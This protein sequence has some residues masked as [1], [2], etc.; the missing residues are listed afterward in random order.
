MKPQQFKAM[1]YLDVALG[2]AIVTLIAFILTTVLTTPTNETYKYPETFVPNVK[3]FVD[4]YGVVKLPQAD[5]VVITTLI[6]LHADTTL[7]NDERII[8][9]RSACNVVRSK[10][11]LKDVTDVICDARKETIKGVLE[12]V[13]EMAG[14][15][16][17]VVAKDPNRLT[18]AILLRDVTYHDIPAHYFPLKYRRK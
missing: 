12:V 9:F 7:Q 14:I 8:M 2:M 5:R 4:I 17:G 18:Y 16:H 1:E 15:N 11:S 13:N 10:H 3:D 6:G